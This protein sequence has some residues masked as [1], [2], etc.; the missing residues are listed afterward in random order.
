VSAGIAQLAVTDC[1]VPV[2]SATAASALRSTGNP[3]CRMMLR[4]KI[5]MAPDVPTISMQTELGYPSTNK[6]R[7]ID[8]HQ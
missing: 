6:K 5:P 8:P 1:N 7:E 4:Y 3:N 2:H